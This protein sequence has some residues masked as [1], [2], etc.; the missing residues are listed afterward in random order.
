MTRIIIPQLDANLVDVTITTWNKTPGDR[1]QKDET[2]A[3]LTT[4][5][6][7][8][9]LE[10]PEDG[11]LLRILAPEK[12]VVPT[13][14]I[15]AL[16]GTAGEEDA[17]AEIENERIMALYRG[18]SS[19]HAAT[20]K[21]ERRERIRATPKARRLA[22]KKGVTLEEIQKKTGVDIV[23]EDAVNRFFESMK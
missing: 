11:E 3:E 23:D 7:V 1:V 4:D 20:E 6:A 8:Y 21:R 9:E 16:T 12:S 17:E 18:D 2:I 19:D 14:Y 10:A 15:V 13:G 5:K 22:R